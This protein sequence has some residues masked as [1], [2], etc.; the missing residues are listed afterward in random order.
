ML[1]LHLCLQSAQSFNCIQIKQVL[2]FFADASSLSAL[3]DNYDLF[4]Y[5]IVAKTETM[6]CSVQYYDRRKPHQSRG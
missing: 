2:L 3:S 4:C 1:L 6:A 5:V